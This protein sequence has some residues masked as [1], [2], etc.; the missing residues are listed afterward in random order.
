MYIFRRAQER[1]FTNVGWLKSYHTFSFGNYFDPLYIGFESLR[2]INEDR[3]AP[4]SGFSAHSHKDMEIVSYVISGTLQHK[5]SM[6]NG[7]LIKP[8]EVQRMSAGS[9]VTHSEINPS[10]VEEVHFLQIWL[11]PNQTNLT[12]SYDQKYFSQGD[13]RKGFVLIASQD[14]RQGSLLIHQDAELR[15]AILEKSDAPLTYVLRGGRKAWI[16]VV[17]GP[18]R[19]NDQNLEEGDAIGVTTPQTMTFSTTEGAE[20]LLFDLAPL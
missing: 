5:D 4:S 1:G 20:V 11:M 17:S 12:P 13:K 14:G 3:V 16:H 2:V 7:S 18:L 15:I 10:Q 6:G 8:G 9:G 19:V